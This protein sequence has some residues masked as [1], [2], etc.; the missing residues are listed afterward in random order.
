[1]MTKYK[2]GK[3]AREEME[4]N[5]AGCTGEGKKRKKVM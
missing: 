2:N 5:S 3:E 1:M 4:G